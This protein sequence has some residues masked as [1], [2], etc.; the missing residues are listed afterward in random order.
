[1][2]ATIW[3]QPKPFSAE[4]IP[5]GRHNDLVGKRP[6]LVG[7]KTRIPYRHVFG[8]HI[9]AS[10]YILVG[11]Q[12]SLSNMIFGKV[13]CLLSLLYTESMEGCEQV[14]SLCQLIRMT[15]SGTA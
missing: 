14:S 8:K 9:G 1:M 4:L 11:L 7:K 13:K 2:F 12:L 5:A 15:F 6:D 10:R 3:K